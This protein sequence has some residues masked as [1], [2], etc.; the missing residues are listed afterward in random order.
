MSHISNSLRGITVPGGN[1]GIAVQPVTH[2][3]YPIP[4]VVAVE[5]YRQ[6]CV[7]RRSS[8]L[9]RGRMSGGG[10]R[11]QV[12]QF[13]KAARARLAFVAGNTD[14]DF[15]TMITLTYPRVYPCDG[16]TVKAHLNTFL[17]W[18]RKWE[19]DISYLWFLEF[20]KR[21]A[22]HIHLMTTYEL[23][24]RL[25]ARTDVYR[26]IAQRWYD[27][28]NSKDIRHLRA[29]T[30]TERVRSKD[31]ARHYA[32]K[33]ASKMKQKIV[34]VGFENVGRFWGCSRDVPP[35]PRASITLDDATARTALSG[36]RW[37]RGD[38]FV[39]YH[40][41]YNTSERYLAFIRKV[42]SFDLT[43]TEIYDKLVLSTSIQPQPRINTKGATLR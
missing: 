3:R 23:P 32:V 17:T 13:S 29:G 6:D 11:Q 42:E 39:L 4:P 31:G 16:K 2:T 37:Y 22:P 24:R 33:Y 38:G 20:Q 43:N 21:G 12:R 15:L 34:P 40:T 27:I 10:T 8:R 28:A 26:K 35:K 36:W 18:F 14:I 41:L 7:V 9:G 1:A 19:S 25:S 30:R 5:V